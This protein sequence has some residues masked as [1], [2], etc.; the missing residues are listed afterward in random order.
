[1][2]RRLTELASDGKMR[3]TVVG[4]GHMLGPRG[5]PSL[6]CEVALLAARPMLASWSPNLD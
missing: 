6:L 3:F 2:A 5:I 1:M 4:A